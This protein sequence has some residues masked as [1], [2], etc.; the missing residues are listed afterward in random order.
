MHKLVLLRHGQSIWNLENRY[1][2]WTDVDLTE[3]GAAEAREA[4]RLLKEA[5]FEFDLCFTS[6]LRRAVETLWI[7]LR[8]MDMMWLPTVKAWQLNERH[9]GSLQGSNKAES[10]L[11][12]G[13]EQVF[14]WRRSYATPPPELTRDDPRWPGRE[15]K[16]SGIPADD[17]PLSESLE[18]TVNRVLPYW[19][20]VITP[21]ARA[22]RLVLV[23]AHGNSLRALVKHLDGMTDR[24]VTELNIPTGIPL[25][26]ELDEDM[27]ALRRYYLGDPEH[28]EDAAKEVARQ[29]KA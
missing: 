9:Y 22:G 29:A 17:I 7:T 25:V 18:D 8:E 2:G 23:V 15:R 28:A 27:R 20:E 21:E 19:R 13:E 6:Y 16:Y 24:E 12:Y 4:G 14:L 26:Y 3:K 11:E 5:G 10:T 1:T